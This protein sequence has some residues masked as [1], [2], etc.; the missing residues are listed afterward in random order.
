MERAH[1]TQQRAIILHELEKWPSK[2]QRSQVSE[3]GLSYS[4]IFICNLCCVCS[5]AAVKEFTKSGRNIEGRFVKIR[6]G[7]AGQSLLE[8]TANYYVESL[9]CLKFYIF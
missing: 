6:E 9:F 8:T 1:P 7:L 2:P 3:Q 5:L 4:R